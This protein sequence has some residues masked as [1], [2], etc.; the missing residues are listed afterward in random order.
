VKRPIRTVSNLVV[1]SGHN[2]AKVGVDGSNPFA[3]SKISQEYKQLWGAAQSGF[4]HSGS[5]SAPSP[6]GFKRKTPPPFGR[7]GPG[8]GFSW[9]LCFCTPVIL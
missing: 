5:R 8:G 7:S 2:L 3:R 9:H 1:F 4:S 6:H